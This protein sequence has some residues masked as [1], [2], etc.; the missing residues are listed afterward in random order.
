MSDSGIIF[1]YSR[2]CADDQYIIR[3]CARKNIIE[4]GEYSWHLIMN[5]SKKKFLH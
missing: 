1:V 5:I 3:E 4:K 2:V